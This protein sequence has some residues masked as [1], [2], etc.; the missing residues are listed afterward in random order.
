MLFSSAH[1]KTNK[2]TPHL[3]MTRLL[4]AKKGELAFR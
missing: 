2:K 1:L 3:G 4:K